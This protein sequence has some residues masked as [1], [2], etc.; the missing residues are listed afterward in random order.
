MGSTTHTRRT[1][2]GD[3]CEMGSSG[4]WKR[5]WG[6]VSHERAQTCFS[7]LELLSPTGFVCVCRVFFVLLFCVFL[8]LFL[9]LPTLG[10]KLLFAVACCVK[11]ERMNAGKRA[12]PAKL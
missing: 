12:V 8:F 11:A 7:S 5:V 9:L 1:R 10:G 6:L 3:G 2:V 4:K